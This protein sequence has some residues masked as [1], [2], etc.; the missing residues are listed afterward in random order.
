[1]NFSNFITKEQSV[2]LII[3]KEGIFLFIPWIHLQYVDLV[4]HGSS[5]LTFYFSTHTVTLNAGSEILEYVLQ[6]CKKGELGEVIS[7][8]EIRITLDER[9][10]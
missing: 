6:L 9:L 8:K 5:A 7:S 2:G 10:L 3:K 1:M 4:S